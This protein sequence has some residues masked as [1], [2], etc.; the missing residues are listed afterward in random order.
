MAL[1]ILSPDPSGDIE[2]AFRNYDWLVRQAF[3]Q[4]REALSHTAEGAARTEQVGASQ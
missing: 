2:D 4:F 1:R 3:R